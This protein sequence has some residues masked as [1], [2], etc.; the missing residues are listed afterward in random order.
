[1]LEGETDLHRVAQ[2][3]VDRQHE[4]EDHI[5][6]L[7]HRIDL[8]DARSKRFKR[9]VAAL[10]ALIL[11]LMQHAEIPRL[12]LDTATLSVRRGP[13]RVIVTDETRLPE[14]CFR[15]TRKPNLTHIKE[16]IDQGVSVPGATLSN[17]E[18][19]LTMGTK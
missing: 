16:L 8:N 2:T 14:D 18:P 17:A 10:R 11:K 9:R 4:D 5:V 12:Q 3:I 13:P 19:S 7:D 1:M 6:S 15:V